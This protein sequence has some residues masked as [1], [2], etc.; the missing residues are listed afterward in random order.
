M[1]SGAQLKQSHIL[2]VLAGKNQAAVAAAVN[3]SQE[4]HVKQHAV[5]EMKASAE[6]INSGNDYEKRDTHTCQRVLIFYVSSVN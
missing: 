3:A 2:G 1:R 4:L 5:L 6:F